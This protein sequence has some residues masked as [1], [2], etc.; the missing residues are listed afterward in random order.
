MKVYKLKVALG[1]SGGVDSSVAAKLLIEQGYEVTGFFMKLWFDPTCSTARDNACC[2]ERALAD[3]RK[4][5]KI[6]DIPLYVLDGRAIFKEKITD[7]FLAESE[8]L[9]T[10][11]PCVSCNKYIKFGW[12]LDF[13]LKSGFDRVATGHYAR[14]S[15]DNEGYFHL[16]KGKDENKDQSYFLYELG[17]DQLSK[18]LFPIGE[19]TKPEVRKL[20]AKW[21]LPT[22]EKAESQELCF[23]QEKDHRPFLKRNL[24]AKNFVPGETVDTSGRVVGRHEGLVNYT[25]GQRKGISRNSKFDP[26]A[27]GRN[28]NVQNI[29]PL[30]VVG[31]DKVKNRL[32]VGSDSEVYSDKVVIED[33]VQTSDKFLSEAEVKIRFKARLAKAK[34]EKSGNMVLLKFD[35]PQRAITPGQSAVLFDGEEVVGGGRIE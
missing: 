26:P 25:I 2:D 1:M 14:I 20:A 23:I 35:Q 10:P 9:R 11:N 28:S 30:Y 32:I 31:F 29:K 4:V 12:F 8:Q 22:F 33:F 24:P 16:L 6:L 5:A 13:A 18:I 15:R 7:R 3:A 21:S 27:G 17:Q 19:M 34:V